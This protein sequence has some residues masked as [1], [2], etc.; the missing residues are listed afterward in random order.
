VALHHDM[1]LVTCFT[2]CHL[3]AYFL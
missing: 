2:T 1:P 3:F